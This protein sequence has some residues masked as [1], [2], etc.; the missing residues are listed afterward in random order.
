[1]RRDY[2]GPFVQ[3]GPH[4]SWRPLVESLIDAAGLRPAAGQCAVHHQPADPSAAGAWC[5]SVVE[6]P[7]HAPLLADGRLRAMPAFPFDG[8][9]NAL[10]AAARTAVKAHLAA[11]GFSA[12][13]VTAI[14]GRDSWREVY[15]AV[16][17][18]VVPGVPFDE[19]TLDVLVSLG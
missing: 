17:Q 5:L 3:D 10:G 4:G 7:N 16:G 14:D 12:A 13:E 19:N 15:R 9:W 8:K 1:M 6:L 18:K 11:L 2:I